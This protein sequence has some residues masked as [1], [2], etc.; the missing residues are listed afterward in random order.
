MTQRPDSVSRAR[1]D[2]LADRVAVT[3]ERDELTVA[4]PFTGEPLGSVPACTPADVEAA[5]ERARRAQTDWAARSFGERAAVVL[6]YHDLVLDRREE[7]LDIVVGEGGKARSDAVEELLDVATTARHYATHGEAY[8]ASE[9]RRGAIPLLTKT[10]ENR[11][12]IGVAALVAPWNYPLTLA[13]SDA[14]PALLAGNAVVL[15]PA[16]QTPF[17]ALAAAELLSEAG[18]PEGLF[19]VVTGRG[20]D[21]GDALVANADYVG[22]TGSTEAGREVAASAGRHL[23]KHSLELGGKNPMLV[24]SDA[25]VE[26]AAAG[27]A[28]GAFTSAGQL[29]LSVERIYVESPLYEAFLDA[30]VSRTRSLSLGVGYGHDVDVG[31]LLSS[32]QLEKV[33]SHVDDAVARGASVETGGR[34]RPDLGPYVFEP[35]ILTGVTPEMTLYD[36][37]TFGP[38]AA[39]YEV[40]DEAA[41]VRRANDSAYGLN[42]S[43]WTGD[44]DRGERIARQIRAGTVNVNDAYTAAWASKDAPMGGVKDSGLGRRHGRQGIRRYTEPQTVATQRG[45]PMVPPRGRASKWW[46]RAMTATLRV[47]KE[48]ATRLP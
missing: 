27:A 41:A 10:V 3:G 20:P 11:H 45:P 13:V 2:A 32:G 28:K 16:E 39:V 26:S 43:V 1:L 6:R 14:L 9:R 37:E 29:C 44:R 46:T 15:K 18:L 38:V 24:L 36:E 33:R 5:V 8:L 22:F 40:A 30:F 17:S 4:E 31:S 19:Q 48:V 25:D 47:W 12:P 34:H 7:V 21:L 42:A 35:T 23:T